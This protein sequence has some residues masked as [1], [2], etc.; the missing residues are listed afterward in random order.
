[1]DYPQT[2]DVLISKQQKERFVAQQMVIEASHMLL[3]HD[4]EG[5]CISHSLY[6]VEKE[7]KSQG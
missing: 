3:H 5:E 1:M 4:T 2:T 6:Y 7:K